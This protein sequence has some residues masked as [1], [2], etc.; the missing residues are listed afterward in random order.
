MVAASGGRLSDLEAELEQFT[1]NVWG[2]PERI[3]PAHLTSSR[4]LRAL[5]S[6]KKN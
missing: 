3:R 6:I 5:I 1:M 2:A 4:R